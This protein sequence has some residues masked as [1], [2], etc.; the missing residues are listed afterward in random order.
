MDHISS[1][2]NVWIDFKAIDRPVLPFRLPYRYIMYTESIDSELLV[3]EGL[4]D[5]LRAAGLVGVDITTGEFL[6]AESWGPVYPRLS[7]PDRIALAIARERHIT[8]L[9]GDKALRTAA[10]REGV[11]VMGTLGILD[12]L[13]AGDY[14]PRE[15]YARCLRELQ[16]H[17]GGVVRLPQGELAR[18]LDALRRP[19][20]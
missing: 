19:G 8:L 18:R 1:D 4:K 13:Y 20:P 17:N 16:R 12:Q 6:L 10:G 9:T 7:V 11:A 15:E 5:E 2:T 14:I 3:P